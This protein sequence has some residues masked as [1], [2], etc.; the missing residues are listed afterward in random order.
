[1]SR[2]DRTGRVYDARVTRVIDGDTIVVVPTEGI[3]VRL[4]DCWAPETRGPDAPDGLKAREFLAGLLP[5][6]SVVR[7]EA[8]GRDP[9]G[10]ELATAW[11][12]DGRSAGAEVVAAGHATVGRGLS[13]DEDEATINFPEDV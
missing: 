1:M 3:H 10:R 11:L 13:F 6:G 9:F 2:P 8:V 4:L 5:V 7:I 12:P